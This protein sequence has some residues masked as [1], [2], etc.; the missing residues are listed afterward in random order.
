M[1]PS[2]AR[3]A[4]AARLYNPRFDGAVRPTGVAQCRSTADVAACLDY[5][6]STGSKFAI[7]SGGHSYGGW[8]VNDGLLVDVGGLGGITVDTAART[9]RIGAGARLIDVY[10][11]LAAKGMAIAGGSCPTVGLT[12]LLLGGGVGVLS[13]AYG[14]TCDALQSATVVT[15]DGRTRT[16]DAKQDAD[17]FWA[18]RGGGGGSFGAVTELTL[19]VRPA[20][21]VH[22]FFLQWDFSH[23]ADVLS[24][25]QPWI[26]KADKALWSTCKLLADP[27]SGGLRV[28]V[29]GTWIGAASGLTPTLAP[30]LAAVGATPSANTVN[31]LDYASAMLLE[32]GCS[33]KTAAQ[34]QVTALGHAARQPF[35]ATSAIL[36]SP[37]PGAAIAVAVKQVQAA[38]SVPGLVEGGVSFDAL[39]GT[40]ATVAPGATAFVHRQALASVQYTATWAPAGASGKVAD[41][42]P[43]DSYVRGERA[44]LSRWTGSGAYVNYADSSIANYPAA[45]WGANYARLQSVKKQYDPHNL[46]TFAQAVKA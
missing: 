2:A 15:A 17:L 25:W 35:S 30:L 3:F 14:L 43:F 8:S 11:T 1:L 20:P 16:V 38:M 12:G 23:A 4:G 7:R 19:A 21:T 39:G 27:G 36:D 28:T 31:S 46:F 41:A 22:T 9:A 32:A 26:A 44:A 13:R 10:A 45:Y 18:L 6:L 34:C 42:A 37:L 29:S 5:V 40:V 33:G 24:A